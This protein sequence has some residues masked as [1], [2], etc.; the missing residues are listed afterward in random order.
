MP[1]PWEKGFRTRMTSK[2]AAAFAGC[3]PGNITGAIRR[4]SLPAKCEDG[5]YIILGADLMKW[6]AN[7]DNL[8]YGKQRGDK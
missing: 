8:M 6:R 3:T 7:V 2:E 4:G 5:R 1:T